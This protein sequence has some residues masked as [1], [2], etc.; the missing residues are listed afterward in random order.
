MLPVFILFGVFAFIN[1]CYYF[2]FF[3]FSKT[4]NKAEENSEELSVSVV[5]CAKNEAENLKRFLPAILAQKYSNFEVILIN[6]ASIDDTLEVMEAFA[7]E[8]PKVK[9]VNVENNETF[10][11]NK[12]YALTLG[13][14]KA[15]NQYLLF[16][17]AD[18]K[19][20]TEFWIKEMAANFSEKQ[21]II[22]GYG[23]YFKAP[24]F[25]NKLI[26]FETL[27]TAVQYLSFSALGNPYMGVGRNLAYTAKEF[28]DN[29]G[30]ASHLYIRSG[31]DDLFVNQA[32][33][34]QNTATCTSE[35]SFTRSPAKRSLGAWFTQKR[36]H[37]S[38]AKHYK[39]KHKFLLGLFY[40]S[41]LLFWLFFVLCI[42][43]NWKIA[44]A[45]LIFRLLIQFLVFQ[46]AANKLHEKDLIWLF[47][48]LECFLICFQLLIFISNLMS[49]PKHWK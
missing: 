44:V 16:T 9:I 32:A 41:Q 8:N 36:R 38:V 3:N 24:G 29:K 2:A 25:L 49:K 45:V 28:Y 48:F 5:I 43:I 15:R 11:A 33:N 42:F 22:L 13:I 6:D 35:K 10:W 14:K 4:K 46:K 34:K 7:E 26:R 19:P 30:F 31:D 39:F 17:D 21:S 12:K 40:L 20:E 1:L 23:G 27:L 37:S 18:C 47:P